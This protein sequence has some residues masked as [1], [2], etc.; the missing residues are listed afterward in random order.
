M[1]MY[2]YSADGDIKILTVTAG[3]K[4][5]TITSNIQTSSLT[6]SLIF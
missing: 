1:Y 6:L 2:T 3:I 5:S 4:N